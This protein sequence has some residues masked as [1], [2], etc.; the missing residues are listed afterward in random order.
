MSTTVVGGSDD[1]HLIH[2]EIGNQL[3]IMLIAGELLSREMLSLKPVAGILAV[4]QLRIYC[5]HYS[6]LRML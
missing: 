1:P 4:F 2:F 3:T 6:R 5:M